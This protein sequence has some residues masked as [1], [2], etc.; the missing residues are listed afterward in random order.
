MTDTELIE[1]LHKRRLIPDWAYYQL[2]GKDAA[3]NYR[4]IQL[5]RQAE[6]ELEEY[7][8]RRR[9]EIDAEIEKQVEK[10]VK[11]KIEKA[12]SDLFKGLE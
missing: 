10:E 5:E 11:P 2:N 1:N 9:A 8:A 7:M 3:E 4:Q 12:L 6:K